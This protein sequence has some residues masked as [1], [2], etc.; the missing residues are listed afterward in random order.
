MSAAG[1]ELGLIETIRVRAGRIPFLARH[2]ARLAH[3]REALDLPLFTRDPEP[4]IHQF[5]GVGEGVVRLEVR[6]G[7]PTVTIREVPMFHPLRVIV[8]A[9]RHASYPHK[10]TARDAFDAA[11]AEALAAGADDA[12]VIT[13]DGFVA[14]GTVWAVCW[15]EGERLRAPL[16]DLG[17]LPGVGRAR[18]AELVSLEEGRFTLA[19]LEGRSLCSVNAVRG[20]VPIAS[21]DGQEVPQDQRTA[22]LS[23]R[24][25][26]D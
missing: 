11:A 25:W 2:L 7:Q 18:V 5:A 16:L 13:G 22:E 4:L 1:P 20:I 24:F 8:A 10:T 23:R 26:P 3:A 15:W 21:L 12:L 14:E 9:R 19:D 17:I 6:D